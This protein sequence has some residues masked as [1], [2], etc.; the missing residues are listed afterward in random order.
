MTWTLPSSAASWTSDRIVSWDV[1]GL[2]SSPRNRSFHD[3]EERL[4][5]LP[6]FVMRGSH[7]QVWASY[8]LGALA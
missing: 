7:N 4:V 2:L 3:I 8:S 6:R 1:G 5:D